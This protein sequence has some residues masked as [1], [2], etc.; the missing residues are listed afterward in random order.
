MNRHF[1][2]FC[3]MGFLSVSLAA[4]AKGVLKDDRDGK[5]YKTIKLGN[6]TWMAENLNLH[7]DD[8]W[9]YERKVDNCKKYG[10]LY[11]WKKAEKACPVGWHLPSRS[12]WR[13]LTAYVSENTKEKPGNALRTKDDWKEKKKKKKI[14]DQH[15][16][17]PI[18]LDEYETINTGTDELGFGALPAG[19][20]FK[21]GARSDKIRE[22]A[23][24]WS[25]SREKGKKSKKAYARMLEFGDGTFHENQYSTENAFSVRCVK[26]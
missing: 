24:F 10:R 12:E 9:C 7:M 13:T 25:S 5:T 3:V 21:G 1:V 23:L 17:E 2:L 14:Y 19:F 22:R 8:S 11:T 18:Y 15:T 16:G 6:Q 20:V 26:D 4:P